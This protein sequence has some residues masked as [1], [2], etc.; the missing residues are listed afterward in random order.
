MDDMIEFR[1]RFEDDQ[2]NYWEDRPVVMTLHG[3]TLSNM[4]TILAVLQALYP[5]LV[6]V[7]WNHTWSFQGH[8]EVVI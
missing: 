8:Y 7:R 2:F 5:G 4:G 6:E 3:S 1:L